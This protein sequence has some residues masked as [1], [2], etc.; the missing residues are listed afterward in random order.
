MMILLMQWSENVRNTAA[1]ST[2]TK[3]THTPLASHSRLT[4]PSEHQRA[5]DKEEILILVE[6]TLFRILKD[7]YERAQV[8]GTFPMVD[9]KVFDDTKNR[10]SPMWPFL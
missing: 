1:M 10:L 3:E 6:E 8:L 4:M 7:L 2:E 9:G 5:L